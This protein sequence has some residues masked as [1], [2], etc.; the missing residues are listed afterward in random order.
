MYILEKSILFEHSVEII[1]RNLGIVKN[2]LNIIFTPILCFYLPTFVFSTYCALVYVCLKLSD[3]F[4]ILILLFF[5][6]FFQS[7]SLFYQRLLRNEPSVFENN[8]QNKV[9]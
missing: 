9:F 4:L 5:S 8:L 7:I 2:I 6:R 1:I 3:T